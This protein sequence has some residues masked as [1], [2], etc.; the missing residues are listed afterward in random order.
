VA[1]P[2]TLAP[3]NDPAACVLAPIGLVAA[4]FGLNDSKAGKTAQGAPARRRS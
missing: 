3:P 4:I 2:G 1:D